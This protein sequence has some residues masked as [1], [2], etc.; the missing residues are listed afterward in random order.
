MPRA[1]R[2]RP[3]RRAGRAATIPPPCASRQVKSC[4]PCSPAGRSCR[5]S[6]TGE[7]AERAVRRRPGAAV[8]PAGRPDP[9]QC[10]LGP[11]A[12]AAPHPA[13]AERS[14]RVPPA[15]VPGRAESESTESDVQWSQTRSQHH[16][17][18]SRGVTNTARRT[19]A[20][21]AQG[22]LSVL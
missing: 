5:A 14:V 18:T 7:E 13:R 3:R 8:P 9:A 10:Q 2:A 12:A 4:G 20:S 16:R 15:P 17:Q 6:L 11:L 1:V 21:R 19:P 22:K